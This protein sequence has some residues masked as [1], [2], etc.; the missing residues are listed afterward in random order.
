MRS[1]QNVIEYFEYLDG[2]FFWGEEDKSKTKFTYLDVTNVLSSDQVGN[3]TQVSLRTSLHS[4]VLPL[5][6]G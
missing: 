2:S 1:E 4:C 6:F 3:E 5:H